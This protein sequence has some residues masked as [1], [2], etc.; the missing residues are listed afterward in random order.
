MAYEGKLTDNNREGYLVWVEQGV[1]DGPA[2]LQV[3]N[4]D[5]NLAGY[6]FLLPE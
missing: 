5:E 2:C 1:A 3:A 6:A 4:D